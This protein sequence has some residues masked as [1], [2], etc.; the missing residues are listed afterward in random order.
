[1]WNS[2]EAIRKGLTE[3]TEKDNNEPTNFRCPLQCQI[4]MNLVFH[5]SE[6]GSKIELKHCASLKTSVKSSR[7]CF[8]HLNWMRLASNASWLDSSI[9]RAAV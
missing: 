6:D 3:V 7:K 2:F 4:S 8:L 5:I 9:G 1:M